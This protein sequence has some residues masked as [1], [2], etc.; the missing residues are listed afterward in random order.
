ME[1]GINNMK[2]FTNVRLKGK[3]ELVSILVE[4]GKI[5]KIAEQISEECETIDVGGNLVI[6]P[7]VDPHL[8][9][10]YVFTADMGEQNRNSV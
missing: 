7:Y 3:K 2:K 9:L 10:D 8:H 6:P 4:D 5:K 1:K